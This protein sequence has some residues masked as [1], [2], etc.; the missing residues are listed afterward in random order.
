MGPD[1]RLDPTSEEFQKALSWATSG[2]TERF[3][4]NITKNHLWLWEERGLTK[5]QLAEMFLSDFF[6]KQHDLKFDKSKSR[7][8]TYMLFKYWGF[9]KNLRRDIQK[10]N[11]RL[12]S[13]FKGGGDDEIG[14]DLL[15]EP[16]GQYHDGNQ[17]QDW[18]FKPTE[19]GVYRRVE[20][21]PYVPDN[22]ERK[23][24]KQEMLEIC[25]DFLDEKEYPEAYWKF[26]YGVYDAD[27]VVEELGITKD[28]VYKRMSKIR[29][30]LLARL[31]RKGYTSKDLSSIFID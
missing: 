2:K 4:R 14:H 12:Y 24:L 29:N 31:K 8:G 18:L 9:L 25:H 28:Y 26:L 6:S 20:M 23:F 5:N 17:S 1:D 30:G 3:G 22:P 21:T 19:S 7:L 13:G 15:L 16:K 27:D 11:G 10:R